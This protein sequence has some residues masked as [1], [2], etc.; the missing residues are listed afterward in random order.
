M[1]ETENC[2]TSEL[3]NDLNIKKQWWKKKSWSATVVLTH[4]KDKKTIKHGCPQP[5]YMCIAEPLAMQSAPSLHRKMIT[6][7]DMIGQRQEQG[8]KQYV[9]K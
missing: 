2:Y 3:F 1:S 7:L 8:A 6:Q 4:D 5:E 9:I